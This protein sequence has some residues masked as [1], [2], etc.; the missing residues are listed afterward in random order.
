MMVARLP[1]HSLIAQRTLAV[2]ISRCA[3][4]RRCGYKNVT[5]GLRRIEELCHGHLELPDL[6]QA[7]PSALELPPRVISVVIEN[8]RQ[9]LALE[10]KAAYAAANAAWRAAFVPHA[11]VL[12]EHNVPHPIFVAAAFG[13]ERLLR[14][15]LDTNQSDDTF[16][17]QAKSG[18]ADK[19]A[20][21]RA[22]SIPAFGRPTGFVVN[23]TPDRAI[24]H[25][26]DGKPVRGLARAYCCGDAKL[27]INNKSLMGVIDFDCTIGR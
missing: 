7:L 26:L 5:K 20:S 14:I 3:L 1:I 8:T 27:T 13:V 16:A 6:I 2:K 10:R 18:L 24:V 17:L 22:T 4:A 9:A 15:E 23:L 19:L 12:I 25:D 21:F 11:V